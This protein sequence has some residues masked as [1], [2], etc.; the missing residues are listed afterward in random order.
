[1]QENSGGAVRIGTRR[2]TDKCVKTAEDW[3]QE[4]EKAC[5]GKCRKYK[6]PTTGKIDVKCGVNDFAVDSPCTK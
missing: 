3:R 1:V 6:N 4:A 2:A 5:A